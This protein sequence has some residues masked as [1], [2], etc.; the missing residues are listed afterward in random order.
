M[1]FVTARNVDQVVQV[2][3]ERL[4]RKRYAITGGPGI[5]SGTRKVAGL[6]N[7]GRRHTASL[8]AVAQPDGTTSVTA[9][10]PWGFWKPVRKQLAR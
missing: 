5:V 1:K 6:F 9:T 2:G 7:V 10:G 8:L 4:M 3:T